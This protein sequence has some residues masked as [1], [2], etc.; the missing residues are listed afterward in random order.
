MLFNCA[1]ELPQ[2]FGIGDGFVPLLCRCRSKAAEERRTRFDPCLGSPCCEK[3]WQDSSS[4]A[5]KGIASGRGLVTPDSYWPIAAADTPNG[6]AKLCLVRSASCRACRSR[7][8]SKVA[9]MSWT[10]GRLDEGRCSGIAHLLLAHRSSGLR[11][12]LIFSRLI[13]LTQ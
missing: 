9:A 5:K 10:F 11:I 2:L 8:P 1:D 4:R 13:G 12:D 3:L 7:L 6:P